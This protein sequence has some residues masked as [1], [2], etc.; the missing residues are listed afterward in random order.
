MASKKLNRFVERVE[1][2]RKGIKEQFE[3]LLKE[4]AVSIFTEYPWLESF[5][6][7]Q[8]APYFNDGEQCEFSVNCDYPMLTT[9]LHEG[10]SGEDYDDFPGEE[11]FGTSEAEAEECYRKVRTLLSSLCK[12][13]EDIFR[14]YTDD[15][16]VIISRDGSII[17]ES[18]EHE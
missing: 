3:V 18:Y 9:K 13:A 17:T 14:L 8:Y 4:E 5:G 15:G 10:W 16:K 1:T 6:W 2:L 7:A 11:E 12:V